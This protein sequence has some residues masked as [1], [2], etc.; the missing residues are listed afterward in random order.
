MGIQNGNSECL[1]SFHSDVQDGCDC[2]H[3]EILQTT[4]PAISCQFELKIGVMHWRDTDISELLKSFHQ[5]ASTLEM[6]IGH[7]RNVVEGIRET[8]GFSIAKFVPFRYPSWLSR[9]P[10]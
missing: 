4:A 2:G 1:K 8:W 7:S 9:W 5:M 10:S 6:Q 3:L